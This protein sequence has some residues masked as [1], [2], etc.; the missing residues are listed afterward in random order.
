MRGVGP[1]ISTGTSRWRG[2]TE[3]PDGASVRP[4]RAFSYLIAAISY[5]MAVSALATANR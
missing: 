2:L 5:E 4:W 1:Q 3:E